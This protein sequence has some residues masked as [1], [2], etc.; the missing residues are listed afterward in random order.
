MSQS[1]KVGLNSW[2]F[3]EPAM[4]LQLWL[5][6]GLDYGVLV[7]WVKKWFYLY[8]HLELFCV[9]WLQ[10][11][12]FLKAWKRY[13]VHILKARYVFWPNATEGCTQKIL[14]KWYNPIVG[15]IPSPACRGPKIGNLDGVQD[16]KSLRNQIL[17][18]MEQARDWVWEAPLA[19]S[20]PDSL[21]WI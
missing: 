3:W 19:M 13:A 8:A 2:G 9:C 7:E 5:D 12:A 21:V 6:I 20:I 10:F 4:E 17:I 18:G 11:F 14:I 15:G 16:A 1:K